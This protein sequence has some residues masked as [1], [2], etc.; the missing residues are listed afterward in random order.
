MVEA[1][2]IQERETE[3]IKMKLINYIRIS[4]GQTNKEILT[5]Y[6][7][8][9]ISCVYAAV[10]SDKRCIHQSTFPSIEAANRVFRK[11]IKEAKN[12]KDSVEFTEIEVDNSYEGKT[13]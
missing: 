9:Y 10:N 1:R 8:S 11:T 13:K 12:K 2:K 5:I 3:E 6:A 7:Q 4:K